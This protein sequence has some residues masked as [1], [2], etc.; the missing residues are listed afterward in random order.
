M[1]NAKKRRRSSLRKA[2]GVAASLV[3]G[4]EV[5]CAGAGGPAVQAGPAPTIDIPWEPAPEAPPA[6]PRSEALPL[7]QKQV[8][9]NG[10]PARRRLFTWTTPDQI[11]ELARD[12][13][14]LTRIESPGKGPTFYDQVLANRA[15]AGDALAQKLRTLVFAKSRFAWPNP[16]ATLLGWPGE[17]YGEKL[18]AVDLKPE[19][20]T[21]K[22]STGQ[23]GWEVF[24]LDNRPVPVA[25]AIAHPERIGAVYFV[26]DNVG[27]LLAAEAGARSAYR[28]YVLCNE[29]MIERWSFGDAEVGWALST[30]IETIEA[31]SA[32]LHVGAAPSVAPASVDAWNLEVARSVWPGPAPDADLDRVYEAAIAFPN[33]SYVL[34][35]ERMAK[36]AL[37]LRAAAKAT[38]PSSL[39]HAPTV[40]P[41]AVAD[42]AAN[43][44]MLPRSPSP[45]ST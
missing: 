9:V 6:P 17:S 43:A 5:S 21:L 10:A 42:A 27:S 38:G 44:K 15:Q 24:D 30:S 37:Q 29:A 36:L 35:H 18:V 20:W 4:G 14:L 13:V 39:V 40:S 12:K 41:A 45:S 23:G 25:D 3:L 22:M 26:Q 34:T 2:A 31:L 7:L 16:W 11:E 8:V 19:A 32:D 1:P 33:P 28:E